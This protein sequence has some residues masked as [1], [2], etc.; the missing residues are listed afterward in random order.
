[1][2]HVVFARSPVAH[3]TIT[4]IDV[5]AAQGMPGVIAVYWA[6]DGNDLGLAPFQGFPMMPA[7]VNRP[8]FAKDTVRFVG[9]IVAAVV[10]ETREQAADAA[11]AIVVD[12]DH[13]ARW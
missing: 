1:M 11:E 5:S 7:E 6:A 4:S 3:G 12:Y 2:A 8:I 10:A 9:D 13:A